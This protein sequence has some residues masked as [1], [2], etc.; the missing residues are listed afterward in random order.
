MDPGIDRDLFF[1]DP[2]NAPCGRDAAG[3]FVRDTVSRF[4]IRASTP[5][6]STRI[7][8]I[9][10]A[11]V[12]ATHYFLKPDD[13]QAIARE[14]L[15]FLPHAPLMLAVDDT[16]FILGFM[17]LHGSHMEALFVDPACHGQGVGRALVS[18]ALLLHPTLTTDVNAQNA[19]AAA[20]YAR[21]GF[22]PFAHSP[23]D[24]QGRS[25][26]LIHLRHEPFL[27]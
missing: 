16:G 3:F 21:M 15:A 26:P 9:W 6:D 13:A 22:R 25:Y 19:G 18:H 10:Q 2:S 1:D 4:Q 23:K 12:S 8:E 14:V 11:A 20:F 24:A 7:C 17:Y 5:D 27:T